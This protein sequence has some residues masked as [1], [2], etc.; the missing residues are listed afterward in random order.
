MNA[1]NGYLATPGEC[2]RCR[3]QAEE[4]MTV[5]LVQGNSGPGWSTYACVPCARV[6]ARSPL[7]PEW[8]RE[9]LAALDALGSRS[10]TRT[11]T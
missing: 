4:R 10:T 5:A 11:V 1:E 2:C 3:A 8:L 9:D 7:A 6:Y